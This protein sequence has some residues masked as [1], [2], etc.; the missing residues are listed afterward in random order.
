MARMAC[1]ALSVGIVLVGMSSTIVNVALPAIR[2]ELAFSDVSLVWVVNAFVLTFAG[3]ML[4]GGRLGDL[5]GYRRM[6]LLGMGVFALAALACGV[7]NT[8][9]L[10]IAARSL[11]GASGAVVF[12]VA[13]PLFVD[14]FGGSS[15]RTR[16][17]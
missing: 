2:H 4:L 14:T 7:A 6:F 8:R 15:D 1:I 12:A 9:P 16:A 10:F 11:Q 17:M 5:F 3:S 13:L